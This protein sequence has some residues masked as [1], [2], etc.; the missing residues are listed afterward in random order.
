MS[1]ATTGS[2]RRVSA[3]VYGDLGGAWS[4]HPRQVGLFVVNSQVY[5]A[6]F[7]WSPDD[8][9]LPALA[10]RTQRWLADRSS[11]PTGL[12]RFPGGTRCSR[13]PG[14]NRGAHST[15]WSSGSTG[16]WFSE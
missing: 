7:E 6:A 14:G 13:R 3:G 9:R 12:L 16:M 15:S 11:R 10:E 2:S 1:I 4:S 5:D 8:P